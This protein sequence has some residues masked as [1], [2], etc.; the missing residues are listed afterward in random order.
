MHFFM[1]YSFIFVLFKAIIIGM[2]L[3]K[4]DATCFENPSQTSTQFLLALQLSI[5]IFV[6]TILRGLGM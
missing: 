4:W 2:L 3:K 6:I 1:L 5:V